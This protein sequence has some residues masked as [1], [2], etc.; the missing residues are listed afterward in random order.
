M[1]EVDIGATGSAA[2]S[3]AF[4]GTRS[5]HK[6][7]EHA[8]H[9]ATGAAIEPVAEWRI[10]DAAILNFAKSGHD[11]T[12]SLIRRNGAARNP[13]SALIHRPFANFDH[14]HAHGYQHKQHARAE[15]DAVPGRPKLAPATR[16]Q[17]EHESDVDARACGRVPAVRNANQASLGIDSRLADAALVLGIKARACTLDPENDAGLAAHGSQHID[18]AAQSTPYHSAAYANGRTLSRPLAAA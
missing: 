8:P 4:S 3:H 6:S 11:D 2:E 5:R 14:G 17:P 9:D 15:P 12:A 1:P 18:R 10:S 16:Y 7:R 13:K